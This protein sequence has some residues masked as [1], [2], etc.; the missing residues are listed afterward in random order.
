MNKKAQKTGWRKLDELYA[1]VPKFR[2]IEGCTECCGVVPIS[3]LELARIG[4]RERVADH[5]VGCC[6]YST[7][8][9]CSIHGKR[10]LTCRLFGAVEH[11]RMTCPHG[12]GPERKLSRGQAARLMARYSKLTG[13]PENTRVL[14]AGM[15]RLTDA[16]ENLQEGQ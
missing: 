8:G 11:P 5:G 15:A 6:P 9:S 14:G 7:H 10:P 3:L 16:L 1:A 4:K 13:V 12:R 2:C